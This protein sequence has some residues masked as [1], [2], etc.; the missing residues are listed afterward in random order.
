MLSGK[1]QHVRILTVAVCGLLLAVSLSAQQRQPSA[2]PA[3]QNQKKFAFTSYLQLRYTGNENAPDLYALRRFK[4]IFDGHLTPHFQ[5]YVQGIFKD[6]NR[7]STDGRAYLQEARV[8]YTGWKYAHVTIGQFKPPV[9]MERFT[10]DWEILTLQRSQ[11]TN[12]LVPDGRLGAS[13]TRDYG[14]QLD[15]WFEGNRSYYAVGVFAGN[16]ANE[17]FRGNGPLVA[18]RFEQVL[19]RAPKGSLRPAD[20]FLG[21]AASTRHD[22]DQDFASALTG[23]SALGYTHFSGRDTR[24]D[25]Y[26]S[27]DY[28]PA[29]FRAEYLYGWFEP[30]RAPLPEVQADGYYTQAAWRFLRVLQAVGEYEAFDPDRGSPGSDKLHW[31]TVGLNWYIRKNLVRLSSDY[32]FK[33]GAPATKPNNALLLQFQ[34]F[35]HPSAVF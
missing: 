16:G 14:A 34:F 2:T 27:A 9:G 1:Y 20:V 10:P 30:N 25:L 19:Y 31:T 23:T 35:L 13:F 15:S 4:L 33:R 21:A 11:A 32:V 12:R 26:A 6:G 5:Y 22:H 18:G 24:L 7:S 8:K 3:K 17:P 28:G 29:S